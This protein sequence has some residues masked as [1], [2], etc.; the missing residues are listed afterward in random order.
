MRWSGCAVCWFGLAHSRDSASRDLRQLDSAFRKS[1]WLY[2]SERG[3]EENRKR[4]TKGPSDVIETELFGKCVTNDP[5][6]DLYE[7]RV[8]FCVISLDTILDAF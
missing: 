5:R 3:R 6:L 8:R 4:E 1:T 2:P 7:S